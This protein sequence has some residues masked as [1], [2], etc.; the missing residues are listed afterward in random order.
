MPG[1]VIAKPS[2]FPGVSRL[3]PLVQQLVERAFPLDQLPMAGGSIAYRGPG[4][5]A[6]VLAPKS[7]VPRGPTTSQM[8][9][10]ATEATSSAVQDYLQRIAQLLNVTKESK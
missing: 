1:P 4:D 2:S 9:Q 8:A 7:V 6:R 3:S 5:I 10:K